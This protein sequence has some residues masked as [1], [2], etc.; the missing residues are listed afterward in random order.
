M[1]NSTVLVQNNREGGALAHVQDS[2]SNRKQVN[3][4]AVWKEGC[5]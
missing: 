5:A 4:N 3:V 1:N 2:K